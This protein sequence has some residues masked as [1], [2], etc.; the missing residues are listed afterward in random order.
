LIPNG[1]YFDVYSF[2]YNNFNF[3]GTSEF[4]FSIVTNLP[5]K[6]NEDLYYLIKNNEVYDVYYNSTTKKYS[7]PYSSEPE[8]V[9]GIYDNSLILAGWPSSSGNIGSGVVGSW[10][11]AFN[12]SREH[13]WPNSKLG[14]D[15]V[16]GSGKNQASDAHNLRAIKQSINSSRSNRYFDEEENTYTPY[17][18]GSEAFYPGRAF[19]GDI[20]RIFMY[21]DLMYEGDDNG[22]NLTL[23]NDINLLY[24]TDGSNYTKDGAYMGILDNLVRWAKEDPVDTFEIKRN[25]SIFSIQGNRNPFIDLPELAE[26]IYGAPISKETKTINYID[27]IIFIGDVVLVKINCDWRRI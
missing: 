9:W 11:Q 4:N 17:T 3:Q 6:L 19:V 26:L 5:S 7:I 1:D 22:C 8:L 27:I 18:I 15:R 20:A 10:N 16:S 23:T 25:E 21:M 12:Y 13:V 2:D 14:M 24:D